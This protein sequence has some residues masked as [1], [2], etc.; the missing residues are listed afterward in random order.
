M[1]LL[2]LK[3]AVCIAVFAG[4]EG[5]AWIVHRYVMHGPLWCWHRS[6][7][8]PGPGRL[9][10][11]DLFALIFALP[12][13]ACFLLAHMSNW[14]L[15]PAIGITA[16]GL[17]YFIFHDGFVQGRLPVP[18]SRKGI[19]RAH[20]Q[21]HRLHHAVATRDGCVSFGF[22]WVKPIRTLKAQL[23]AKRA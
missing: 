20:L 14:W 23:A 3:A 16:Y 13:I 11:N 1:A 17:V 10:R 19:G 15:P 2:A 6:H 5:F 4:M 18:L 22:L 12:A 7:H 9:E 8:T 21:A